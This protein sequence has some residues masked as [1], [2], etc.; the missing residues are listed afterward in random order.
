M[1]K[2]HKMPPSTRQ[3]SSAQQPIP[4]AEPRKTSDISDPFAS[5]KINVP[6]IVEENDKQINEKQIRSYSVPG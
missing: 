2:G 5:G 3:I 1:A 6:Q 4:L